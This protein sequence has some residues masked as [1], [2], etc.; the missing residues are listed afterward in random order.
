MN[1]FRY[2]AEYSIAAA[3]PLNSTISYSELAAKL[4]LDRKQL[5]Q[6]LRQLIQSHVFSEPSLNQVSHTASSKLLITHP[7]VAAFNGYIARDVF[8]MAAKQFEALEH[9]GHGNPHPHKAGLNFACGTDLPMF[10]FYEQPEQKGVR[11]RFSQLMTYASSFPALSNAHVTAGFPWAT[12]PPGSTVVDIAGNVG[13]CSIAIAR[14]TDPSVK[15]VVQDLPQIVA[16]AKDPA[17]SVVPA[18]LRDRFT[19]MEH[20]FYTPQPIKGAAVYFLRMIM[21]DYSDDYCWKILRQ[22]VP[23]MSPD[24]R[25]VIMD[26]VSPPVGVLPTAIERMMRTQDLQMMLLLNAWE[27]DLGEWNDL[28][29]G[30]VR[31]E[32]ADAG[33]EAKVE[34]AKPAEPKLDDTP[35]GETKADEPKDEEAKAEA[36]QTEESKTTETKVEAPKIEEVKIVES[37]TAEPKVEEAKIPEPNTTEPDIEALKTEA[38]KAEEP[39]PKA[40][41]EANGAPIPQP[42]PVAEP[43]ATNGITTPPVPALAPTKRLEI[44]NIVTP[45]GTMMSL[46]EIGFVAESDEPVAAATGTETDGST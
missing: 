23:A 7:G 32:K 4:S 18:D 29:A 17:T 42:E 3:V 33:G 22:I 1:A 30:I 41:V 10:A 2:V 24:S 37:E 46:I 13:H 27:R 21:H 26:Q 9:F 15:L 5:R 25:I 44:K 28:V 11:E 35:E 6:M 36:P 39:E 45:P 43:A 31:E 12:L 40:A 20:D 16:R 34:D 38:P 8:P 14:A 19:F